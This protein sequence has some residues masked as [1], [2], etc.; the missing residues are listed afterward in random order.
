M[1]FMRNVKRWDAIYKQKAR[2]YITSLEYLHEILTLFQTYS[3]KKVLDLGCGSGEYI[4]S[5][6]KNVFEVYGLDFSIE[7][8]EVAKS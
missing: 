3:V 6:A 7:A 1:I 8:I 5:L 2:T 4:V